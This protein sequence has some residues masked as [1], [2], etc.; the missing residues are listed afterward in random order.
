MV[1]CLS[2][3]GAGT[4]GSTYALFDDVTLTRLAPTPEVASR[5]KLYWWI[6]N[7]LGMLNMSQATLVDGFCLAYSGAWNAGYEAQ[8]GFRLV[9]DYTNVSTTVAAMQDHYNQGARKLSID[10]EGRG[11][12]VADA[13]SLTSAIRAMPGLSVIQWIASR[14]WNHDA[15]V[16]LEKCVQI[17]LVEMDYPM[18][19]SQTLSLAECQNGIAYNMLPYLFKP[20]ERHAL[21]LCTVVSYPSITLITW[22]N[23]KRQIDAA[24]A[25]ANS[26]GHTNQAIAF[27][28]PVDAAY[29]DQIAQYA[30]Q[31]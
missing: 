4:G 16:E 8:K 25:Y 26:L 28:Y 22:D 12:S 21:G 20:I 11:F 6:G 1:L 7:Q 30:K 10:M 29:A 5:S 2:W 18:D 13:Q 19:Y 27:Y 17:V 3:R 23:L 14:E 9:G 24:K 31:P 15:R